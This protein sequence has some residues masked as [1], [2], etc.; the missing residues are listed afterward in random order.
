MRLL[1]EIKDEDFNFESKKVDLILREAAR[2]VI[3]NENKVALLYVSTKN[4]YKL[5]GGGVESG[6]NIEQALRREVMEESGCDIKVLQEIG[7]IH[8]YRTH[9]NQFQKSYCFLTEVTGCV[10]QTQFTESEDTDG[11]ELK[12]VPIEEAIELATSTQTADYMGCFVKERLVTFL[13]EAKRI[14]DN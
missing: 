10:G 3:L 8:E 7:E 11:F 1:K 4:F 9:F 13:K 12:W 5:P 6:E 14:I 2:A